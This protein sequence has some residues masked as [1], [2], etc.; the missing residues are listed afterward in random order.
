MTAVKNLS[1]PSFSETVTVSQKLWGMT[2]YLVCSLLTKQNIISIEQGFF[3]TVLSWHIMVHRYLLMVYELLFI[4]A[5][6]FLKLFL[7]IHPFVLSLETR[8]SR[9]FIGG[10]V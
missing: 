10:L 4:S 6:V 7:T 2:L 8:I 9:L 1:K 3:L 5:A